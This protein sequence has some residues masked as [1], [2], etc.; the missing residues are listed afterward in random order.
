MRYEHIN[1]MEGEK[2]SFASYLKQIH[3]LYPT[4][5]EKYFSTYLDLIFPFFYQELTKLKGVNDPY[6][7]TFKTDN[8]DITLDLFDVPFLA[9]TVMETATINIT[10]DA[11]INFNFSTSY[12]EILSVTSG[13]SGT[14]MAD[15]VLQ[16]NYSNLQYTGVTAT[17]T[18]GGPGTTI[19]IQAVCRGV[20]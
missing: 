20:L 8:V 14:I 17:V 3:N 4:M 19:N 1:K 18:G 10:G 9:N 12:S 13:V 11:I 15:V 16:N 5:K 7:D 6:F 2:V